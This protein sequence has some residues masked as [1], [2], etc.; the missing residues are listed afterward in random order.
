MA[1]LE[2]RVVL[3]TMPSTQDAERIGGA[4]VG[5]RLA[6]C[7]YVLPGGTSIFRWEDEVQRERE[8][9]VLLKTTSDRVDALR[10]RVV[11]LHG[12]DVPEFLVLDVT[13]GHQPYLAWVAASVGGAP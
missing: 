2:V 3:V 10:E 5:E 6:A 9:L 1:E 12:Y 8:V 13:S 4:V 7:A 11:A